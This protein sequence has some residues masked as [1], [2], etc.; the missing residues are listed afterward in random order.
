MELHT[1]LSKWLNV[2]YPKFWYQRW[3]PSTGIADPPAIPKILQNLYH[4]FSA[5]PAGL[6]GSASERKAAAREAAAQVPE[7]GIQLIP[8]LLSITTNV[9]VDLGPVYK[10]MY[11]IY[12]AKP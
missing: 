4:T 8:I 12:R 5:I 3:L 11:S 1:P 7:V 9:Y 10:V 2:P 6:G